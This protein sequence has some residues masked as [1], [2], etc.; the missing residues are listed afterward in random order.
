[1]DNVIAGFPYG[2]VI[3]VY[4]TDKFGDPCCSF[5]LRREGHVVGEGGM[6]E[7][8]EEGKPAVGVVVLNKWA[9]ARGELGW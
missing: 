8:E 4:R 5:G 3:G 2:L 9:Y 6:N 7:S 1:M